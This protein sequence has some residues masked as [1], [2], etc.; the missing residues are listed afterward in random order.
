MEKGKHSHSYLPLSGGT[1]SGQITL[2]NGVSAG[3]AVKCLTTSVYSAI[4]YGWVTSTS[5][6]WV[7]VNYPR[8][9]RRSPNIIVSNGIGVACKLKNITTTSAEMCNTDSGSGIIYWIA[10]GYV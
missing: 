8:P 10:C 6:A 3:H 9:F 5:G 2:S 4:A 7:T 1:V